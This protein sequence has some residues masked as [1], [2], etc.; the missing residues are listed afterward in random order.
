MAETAAAGN[1]GVTT[2]VE[3]VFVG[4]PELTNDSY[5]LHH[6]HYTLTRRAESIRF[7][8]EVVRFDTERDVYGLLEVASLIEGY[9]KTGEVPTKT[10]EENHGD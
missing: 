6:Q 10:E 3:R 8:Q 5:K 7:A 9:L 4:V 1:T 2:G